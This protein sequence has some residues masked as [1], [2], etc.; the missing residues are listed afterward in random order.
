MDFDK[1]KRKEINGVEYLI[2]HTESSIVPMKVYLASPW[3][4]QE[5]AYR[6]DR[7]LVNLLHS[8]RYIVNSPQH[9]A[10]VGDI[11]KYE[12]RKAIYQKNIAGILEADLV[13]AITNDKDPGTLFE[14]GYAAAAHKKIIGFFETEDE[15]AKF[16][17]MLELAMY[18]TNTDIDAL[19]KYLDEFNLTT[20]K[21]GQ[22]WTFESE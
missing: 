9:I 10:G 18:H 7:V 13:V 19:E 22:T 1:I 16:N 14:V 4:N 3:F 11:S 5:Q 2:G 15:K 8:A 17:I 12:N 20:E 21:S 6:R